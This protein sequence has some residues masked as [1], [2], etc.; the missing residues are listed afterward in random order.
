MPED[1]DSRYKKIIKVADKYKVDLAKAAIQFSY[2]PKVV[3]TVLVGGSKPYQPIENEKAFD[4][5][6]PSEFWVELKK[7]G[8]IDERCE[9]P[10]F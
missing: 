10:Q 6:I 3:D 8:L 4:V 1:V 2:A 9:T 5:N 7:E